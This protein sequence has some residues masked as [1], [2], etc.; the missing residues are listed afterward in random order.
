MTSVLGHLTG[1]GFGPQYE[2]WM[3]P[4]PVELFDAPVQTFV[5]PVCYLCAFHACHTDKAPKEIPANLKEYPATGST[6]QST[7]HMD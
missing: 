6:C 2:N 5:V 3:S 7:V 4:S 1:V